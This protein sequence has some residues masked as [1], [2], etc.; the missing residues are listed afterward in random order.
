MPYLDGLGRVQY[1]VPSL[2]SFPSKSVVTSQISKRQGQVFVGKCSIYL[3]P[4]DPYILAVRVG[5]KLSVYV[6]SAQCKHGFVIYDPC[7]INGC[8]KHNV[9]IRDDVDFVGCKKFKESPEAPLR[10]NNHVAE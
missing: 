10:C 4:E 7:F 6:M 8:I 2:L 1:I 3:S 5:V 9:T